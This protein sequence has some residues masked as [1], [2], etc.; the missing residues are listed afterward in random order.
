MYR[1]L[2]WATCRIEEI[3]PRFP[4]RTY[5]YYIDIYMLL[6]STLM[7]I[8]SVFLLAFVLYGWPPERNASMWKNEF[9]QWHIFF[10]PAFFP[11]ASIR[12][13]VLEIEKQFVFSYT[14][15]C[16]IDWG[17][18]RKKAGITENSFKHHATE[19]YTFSNFWN[20]IIF[21]SKWTSMGT[22]TTIWILMRVILFL[23]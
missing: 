8:M 5:T 4:V 21:C 11:F 16:Q 19:A 6:S 17:N 23:I 3:N 2:A 15:W 12:Y 20:K 9:S 13:Q 1:H 10:R 18:E 22:K 7:R 14:L